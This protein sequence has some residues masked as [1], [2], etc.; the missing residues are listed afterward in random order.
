[1]ETVEAYLE[2]KHSEIGLL[3]DCLNNRQNLV[4]PRSMAEVIK[5]KFQ[6]AAMLRSEHEL[7]D[8]RA[9]E[10]AWSSSAH[11]TIGPFAFSY[12]YQ[13]AD[14]RVS[15]PSFYELQPGSKSETIYTA[16]GMAAISSLL[17]ASA[18]VFAK[19]DILVLPGTYSETLELIERFVPN[20]RRVTLAPPL[21]D[22]FTGGREPRILVLDSCVRAALFEAALLCDWSK[23]DLLVFDTTC[24]AGRSGRI[25]RVL[26]R[27]QRCKVRIVLVRSH[28]KL[29]SLGAE[30]GRL[31]SA[32]FVDCPEGGVE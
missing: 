4:R 5:A 11:H 21:S 15:G 22:A 1:M 28:N 3:N 27:A 29:D 18:A 20:L 19:A 16:S 10:T 8:W 25:R 23:L 7:H 14:L 24:F 31:G 6:L 30:Y 9:T 32:V 2:R 17:L 13:R 12:D 26:R